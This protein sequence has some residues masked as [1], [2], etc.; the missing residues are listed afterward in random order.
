MQYVPDQLVKILW[1]VSPYLALQF[2]KVSMSSACLVQ[3]LYAPTQ[4]S[5]N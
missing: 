5:K 2:L 1:T 4:M 3:V